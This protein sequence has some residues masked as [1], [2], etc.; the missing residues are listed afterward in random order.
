[1]KTHKKETG[2]LL[3][4]GDAWLFV[5]IVTRQSVPGSFFTPV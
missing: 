4:Q 1:M 2:T 5:D 3:A